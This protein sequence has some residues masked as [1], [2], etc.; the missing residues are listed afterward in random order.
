M[1]SDS[2]SL[3]KSERGGAALVQAAPLLGILV[4]IWQVYVHENDYFI[5]YVLFFG[6]VFV[7]AAGLIAAVIGRFASR[8]SFVRAQAA[9]SLRFHSLMA[10]V[11]VALAALVGIAMLFDNHAWTLSNQPRNFEWSL[12]IAAVVCGLIL[13]LVETA[14]AIIYGLGAWRG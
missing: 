14:R 9:G 12:A 7:V 10:G 2:A 6:G 13:P 4:W 5:Y 8:S 1:A 11:I 3:T